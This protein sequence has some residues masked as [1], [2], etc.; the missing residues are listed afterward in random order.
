MILFSVL[1]CCFI[2]VLY[3]IILS[4]IRFHT[5]N[6][7]QKS[8]RSTSVAEV[9]YISILGSFHQLLMLFLNL[10][11]ILLHVSFGEF[12]FVISFTMASWRRI[13][14]SNIVL[15][16]NN[17]FF[18]RS[19]T[20]KVTQ[21]VISIVVDDCIFTYFNFMI[22]FS[23]CI[24]PYD[25]FLIILFLFCCVFHFF[26]NRHYY[27]PSYHQYKMNTSKIIHSIPYISQYFIE[28]YCYT[29]EVIYFI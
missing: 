10:L 21:I 22:F 20:G 6:T 1:F 12:V 25:L 11:I 13:H 16:S 17:I 23:Y 2:L 26:P 19:F 8:N 28:E 14:L 29:T 4:W 9:W 5:I 15:K 27:F 7:I 18:T 24:V 3:F